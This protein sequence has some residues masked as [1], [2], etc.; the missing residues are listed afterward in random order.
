[1]ILASYQLCSY[2]VTYNTSLLLEQVCRGYN[3]APEKYSG[4]NI[5]VGISR[6]TKFAIWNDFS[7]SSHIIMLS[8]LGKQIRRISACIKLYFYSCKLFSVYFLTSLVI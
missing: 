6:N 8:D 2:N 3:Q 4:V 5:E 1:M 7:K